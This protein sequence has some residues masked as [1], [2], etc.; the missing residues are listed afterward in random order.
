MSTPSPQIIIDS[1]ATRNFFKILSNVLGLKPTPNGIAASLPDGALTRS[2]HTG[3][4]PVPGLPLSACRAQGF[5]SLQSHSPLSICQLCD[6][7]CKAVFTHNNIIIT[8][9]DLFLLTGTSSSTTD[10]LWTLDPLD[11]TTTPAAAPSSPITGS[12]N[13]MFH[14]TLAHATDATQIAF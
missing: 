4:H 7:G 13:A 14:T 3:T 8:H 6:H 5:P 9:N 12:V 1:G 11:P 2:T 10:G